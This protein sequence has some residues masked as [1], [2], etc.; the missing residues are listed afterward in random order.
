MRP[1]FKD[2]SLHFAKST[3][4]NQET[5]TVLTVISTQYI[6]LYIYSIYILYISIQYI[7]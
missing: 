2:L 5:E 1:G 6:M 4:L 7:M 3:D